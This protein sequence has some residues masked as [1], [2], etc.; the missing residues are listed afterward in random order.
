MTKD[1]AVTMLLERLGLSVTAA[2]EERASECQSILADALALQEELPT[3][4][5][6][7][8]DLV[9]ALERREQEARA[10]TAHDF[11]LIYGPLNQAVNTMSITFPREFW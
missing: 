7:V 9:G 4:W 5:F 11:R 1:E 10:G 8:W 2:G 6:E 3:S